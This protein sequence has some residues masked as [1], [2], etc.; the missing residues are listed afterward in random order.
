MHQRRN[1]DTLFRGV[2]LVRLDG[3]MIFGG[4]LESC[5]SL[6]PVRLYEYYDSLTTISAFGRRSRI[7]VLHLDV[8]DVHDSDL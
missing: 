8:S 3:S 5:I 6:F 4:S 2:F 1:L 7:P